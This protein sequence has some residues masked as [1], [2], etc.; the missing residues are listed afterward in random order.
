[1]ILHA[2]DIQRIAFQ[3]RLGIDDLSGPQRNTAELHG[4][5]SHGIQMIGERRAEAIKHFMH[6]DKVGTAHV[7]VRLFG[8]QRQI[9][10]LK[11]LTVE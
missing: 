4:S 10:K 5:F 3:R 7:P 8:N 11:N 2:G 1:M 9:D 6:R